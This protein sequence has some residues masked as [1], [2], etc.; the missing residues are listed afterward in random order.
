MLRSAREAA[1][2]DDTDLAAEP[3]ADFADQQ[4]SRLLANHGGV[5]LARI[6]TAGLN[7]GDSNAH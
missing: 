7:Q 2:D 5:G 6:V 1:E 3:M 4:F